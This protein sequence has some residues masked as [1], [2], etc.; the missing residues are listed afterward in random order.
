MADHM[1][2]SLQG[3]E[4]CADVLNVFMCA[5]FTRDTGQYFEAKP[6]APG[7][8]LEFFAKS[9]VGR[10][11]GLSRGDCSSEHSSDVT[12]WYPALVEVFAPTNGAL[13]GWMSRLLTDM[14]DHTGAINAH[15]Y[16]ANCQILIAIWPRLPPRLR[17]HSRAGHR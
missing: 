15:E 12:A 7:D 13:D 6:R 1:Q 3:A 16:N 2:G 17:D 9:V 10:A 14:T 11:F 5:G 4:P 8:Y